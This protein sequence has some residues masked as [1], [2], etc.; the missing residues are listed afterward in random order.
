MSAFIVGE[1]CIVLKDER[2]N[3]TCMPGEGTLANEVGVFLLVVFF[4]ALLFMIILFSLI[5]LVAGLYWETIL[6]PPICLALWLV[7]RFFPFFLI[8]LFLVDCV[9]FFR[10]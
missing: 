6:L 8:G 9:C 1:L 3:T 10:L 5:L 4:V 2:R 7:A